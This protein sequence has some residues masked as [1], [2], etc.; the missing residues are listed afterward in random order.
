MISILSCNGQK[1]EKSNTTSHKNIEGKQ[2]LTHSTEFLFKKYGIKLFIDSSYSHVNN[3]GIEQLNSL[4]Q[5]GIL[6]IMKESIFDGL[7]NK[8]QT[9][10]HTDNNSYMVLNIL[11]HKMEFE[12]S[13]LRNED[14][15]HLNSVTEK[16]L[17]C[18][19]EIITIGDDLIDIYNV[20][21]FISKLYM[22]SMPIY[23]TQSFIEI[24]KFKTLM[25]SIYSKDS[26]APK[27]IMFN[28][29]DVN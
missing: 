2:P 28:I 24:D 23:M 27:D 22:S 8:H 13:M 15:Q 18:S 21:F 14:F 19:A 6:V 11:E 9:F 3:Y 16:N 17:N 26:L 12:N 20:K 4:T 7:S 1:G 10:I 5:K 25:V 29:S